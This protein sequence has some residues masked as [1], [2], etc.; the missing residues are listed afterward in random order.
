MRKETCKGNA[1]E[2]FCRWHSD[3]IL[4]GNL[5]DQILVNQVFFSRGEMSASLNLDGKWP[6]RKIGLPSV[7]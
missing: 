4:V 1:L 2:G 3:W 5:S 6:E 7:I